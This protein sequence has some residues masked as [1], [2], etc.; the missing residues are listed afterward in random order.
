MH[1]NSFSY[2]RLTALG[3]ADVF[4][5]IHHLIQH[6]IHHLPGQTQFRTVYYN[7][8]I[9]PKLRSLPFVCIQY[10]VRSLTL[11]FCY[12][13]HRI[14]YYCMGDHNRTALFQRKKCQILPYPTISPQ[15]TG[16]GIQYYNVKTKWISKHQTA[17][18]Q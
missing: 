14:H 7:S 3:I 16:V 10:L 4:F 8:W 1:N 15:F 13:M 11:F 12:L 9:L 17:S 6:P 18:H 5:M 2:C